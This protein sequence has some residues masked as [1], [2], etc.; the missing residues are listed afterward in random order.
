MPS[1]NLPTAIEKAIKIVLSKEKAL[2]LSD[3]AH[4]L[5]ACATV[6]SLI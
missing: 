4:P 5:K 2:P 3:I 6:R 1:Q